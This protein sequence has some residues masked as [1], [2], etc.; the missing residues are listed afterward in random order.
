MFLSEALISTFQSQKEWN[1]INV[2]GWILK[3]KKLDCLYASD[4]STTE[5]PETLTAAVPQGRI[6]LHHLPQPEVE[7]TFVTA[8][9]VT[10][11]QSCLFIYSLSC[12]L[13]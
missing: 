1:T 9:F 13:S 3:F 4:S 6:L 10:N 2:Q 8:A 7:V 12:H 11:V 5:S